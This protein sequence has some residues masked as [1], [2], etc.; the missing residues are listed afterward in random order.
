MKLSV[1]ISYY[2]NI[3]NL[4]LILKA[5]DN[6]NENNFEAIISEDDNNKD[7]LSFIEENKHNYSFHIQ[8]LHQKE[9]TGFRKNEMLNKSIMSA[10]S[11][12]I[13]FID[14]DCVPH[15]YFVKEYIKNLKKG[16]FMSGRA[17]MLSKEISEKAVKDISLKDLNYFSLIFSKS[18]K[19]KEAIYFPFFP[20]T[21]KIRGMVGRNW[22]IHKQDLIDIN[23][24]DTDYIFAGVGEDV[25]IEWRLMK[26]GVQRKSIKNKAIVFH[27]YHDKVYSEVNVGNNYKKLEEKKQLN[28]LKCL[29]GIDYKH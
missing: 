16:T 9:D 29:N 7:T 24:F 25:D 23:G 13:A 5:L 14:G 28:N 21:Y 20:L 8:H 26:S 4:K 15:K 6:Q 2:K 12:F 18:Q 27:I 11:N 17:V 10:K 19:I 1:I 22:G 3:E